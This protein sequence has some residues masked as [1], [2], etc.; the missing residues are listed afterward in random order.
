MLDF[1]RKNAS[2]WL[3][4]VM[5]GLISLSFALFFGYSAF[6]RGVGGN[7][8]AVVGDQDIPLEQFQRSYDAASHRLQDDFPDGLPPDMTRF[9]RSNVLEQ[10]INREVAILYAHSLGLRVSDEAVARII[11]N[12]SQFYVD[13]VFNME[14][15]QKQFRPFYL[16]RYGLDYEQAI[17]HDLLLEQL[18]TFERTAQLPSLEEA[19]WQTNVGKQQW[20]FDVIHIPDQ[21]LRSSLAAGDDPDGAA[22]TLLTEWITQWAK[23]PIPDTQLKKFNA[24]LET[25]RKVTIFDRHHLVEGPIPPYEIQEILK[26]KDSNSVYSKPLHIGSDWYLVKLNEIVTDEEASSDGGDEQLAVSNPSETFNLWLD[27][28]RK[29]LEIEKNRNL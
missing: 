8:A 2:S 1:M 5:L 25:G 4:K 27:E 6:R 20:S 19:D 29:R 28:F 21:P 12:Q 7:S 13:G 15:Y 16:R 23:G 9:L 3:I 18:Q 17:R 22:T 24:T 10:L 26:M 14:Y 11:R